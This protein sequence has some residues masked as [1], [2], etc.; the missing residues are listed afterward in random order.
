MTTAA[1]VPVELYR[2]YKSLA[3]ATGAAL[4][5][6]TPVDDLAQP[7][8]ALRRDAAGTAFAEPAAT[9]ARLVERALAGAATDAD[10]EQVRASHRRVRREV[11]RVHPCEYV[12][13]CAGA[14]H[15]HR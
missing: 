4:V 9:L 14:A 10:V 7:V 1:D 15:D 3:L 5:L 11:W 2:R 12:P 6:D 13:C 8:V